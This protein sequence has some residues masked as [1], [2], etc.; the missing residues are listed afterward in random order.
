MPLHKIVT[1]LIFLIG[2][3]SSYAY[4][5]TNF[6]FT[7]QYNLRASVGVDHRVISTDSGL[8]LYFQVRKAGSINVKYTYLLQEKYNSLT[9]DTLSLSID[10]IHVNSGRE[11]Y[12]VNL[13]KPKK[14]LLLLVISDL[15]GNILTIEDIRVQSP[16]GFPTF[17]PKNQ[18]G[19]P[20][21]TSYV[22]SELLKLE[23]E[24]GS[25]HVYEYIDVFGPADPPMG[26]MKPIAPSLDVDS[27]FFI[28]GELGALHDY[29]FYL[30]QSDSLSENAITLLKCP[31]YFPK[32]R[33]L[34]ELIPP[35]TYISTTAELKTL[36]S[37]A[38]KKAFEDFW[39]G[40]YETK[41]GA[42]VAIKNFYDK[43]EDSNELFTDYKL[44]WKTDRGII[45][46]I[47]GLPDRVLR[48]ERS[49]IWA[50]K[51]GP[52]FEFIRISTLFTPSMYSLKRDRDYERLWYTR[53]GEIR[54]G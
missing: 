51:D 30:L 50:Y 43:V 39:L 49:E 23:G 5:L 4:D 10:T 3:C 38:S 1:T 53:V 6:N 24:D 40:I 12:R 42:K 37:N 22:T 27:S 25:T 14:G 46:V 21:L 16:V 41:F 44:G 19:E 20:I 28:H 45:Y 17:L 31:E 26:I 52:T 2:F 29:H 11:T 13:S 8:D 36:S 48:N 15:G 35:V 32:M 47:Y 7:N 18:L 34:D 9:H 33:T 54:K